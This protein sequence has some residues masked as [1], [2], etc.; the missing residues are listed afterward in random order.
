M[1]LIY[2][3]S[4]DN[5]VMAS[6]LTDNTSI[7]LAKRY[8]L[9]NVIA[10]TNTTYLTFDTGFEGIGQSLKSGTATGT[11]NGISY[12][13]FNLTELCIGM[14]VKV[15]GG[16]TNIFGFINTVAPSNA[17]LDLDISA[18]PNPRLMIIRGGDTPTA[19]YEGTMIAKNDT[20]PIG[21]WTF[22]EMYVKVTGS[23]ANFKVWRDDKLI[24]DYSN[25]VWN[26]NSDGG[27][28]AFFNRLGMFKNTYASFST[29]SIWRDHI[30]MTT[31]ERLG[32]TA[33]RSMFPNAD[34]AQ[35]QWTPSSGSSNYLMVNDSV[36]PL[37]TSNVSNSVLN[38]KDLYTVGP[39]FLTN[40]TGG[41]ISGISPFMYSDGRDKIRQKIKVGSTEIDGS[42]I[43]LDNNIARC[44][45]TPVLA[46]NPDTSAPWAI[47]DFSNV[48][49]GYDSPRITNSIFYMNVP[50]NN[51]RDTGGAFGVNTAT[52]SLIA[53][54]N[55]YN[56]NK[57]PTLNSLRNAWTFDG[58]QAIL[59]TKS[60]ADWYVTPPYSVEFEF[61]TSQLVSGQVQY[62]M[63]FGEG[64]GSG[65]TMLGFYINATNFGLLMYD[66]NISTANKTIATYMTTPTLATNTWYKI[67][68]MFYTSN[69]VLRARGYL[70]DVQVFDVPSIQPWQSNVNGMSIGNDNAAS[71]VSPGVPQTARAFF[72]GVRNVI[73]ARNT[74]WD[75][76]TSS[77]TSYKYNYSSGTTATFGYLTV[78]R[79]TATDSVNGGVAWV[80]P[81]YDSPTDTLSFDGTQSIA[82]LNSPAQQISYAGT[83]S[84]SAPQGIYQSSIQFEFNTIGKAGVQIPF[85]HASGPGVAWPLAYFNL[86]QNGSN[87]DLY[88][89]T[90]ANGTGSNGNARWDYA[91]VQ[92]NTWYKV[93]L[94]W[95]NIGGTFNNNT[96]QYAGGMNYI[97]GYLDDVI[98]FD[99]AL[100]S[101]AKS[102]G[103]AGVTNPATAVK[104]PYVNTNSGIS[105]GCDYVNVPS[106]N[107]R[108]QM[109]NI[110]VGR[111]L[112]WPI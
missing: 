91:Q 103:Y 66:A 34:T 28:T 98:K 40:D 9:N 88:V 102:S 101:T 100:D 99:I 93:G 104:I 67:G 2:T 84:N 39:A 15:D 27:T 59:Y 87:Y 112:L 95:Y 110:Y 41:N 78:N 23:T 83:G 7:H 56:L 32:S 75:D 26:T 31:G 85:D 6:S 53:P 73:I 17:Y 43:E 35:K 47:S 4:F 106:L 14:Y 33:I 16:G 1:A 29:T 60:D 90:N 89:Q 24:M 10:M 25:V 82:Y 57:V 18:A 107:F 109:R 22:V 20:F 72:G 46:L 96:K 37:M 50:V 44:V 30:Y 70:N 42:A 79:K 97:R 61:Y 63:N 36:N 68:F 69:T 3:E 38:N 19:S 108:G 77:P 13:G 55:T 11:N 54:N 86:A 64:F 92:A 8:T 71:A 51:Y 21:V 49:I 111:T 76:N 52:T 5:Y 58:S 105:I 62:I 80:L 74:L 48:Q 65:F 12:D 81:S 45:R 94:M